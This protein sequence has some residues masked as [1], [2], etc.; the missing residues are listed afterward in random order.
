MKFQFYILASFV[1]ASLFLSFAAANSSGASNA[2]EASD[3][4]A[5][6]MFTSFEGSTLI[7]VIEVINTAETELL[8][9]VYK[10]TDRNV[11]MSI[12]E[13]LKRGVKVRLIADYDNNYNPTKRQYIRKLAQR[14]ADVR[15]WNGSTGFPKL[16]AKF[17]IADKKTA[18]AGS[19][20]FSKNA[21]GN[22]ELLM[23]FKNQEIIHQLSDIFEQLFE[24]GLKFESFE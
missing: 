1:F 6:S 16:H 11:Y 19:V 23:K 18:L 13:A 15:L 5:V 3:S 2:V 4:N 10:L 20:N 14:G 24:K 12:R 8:A 7:N 22:M 21:D 17:T 9:C